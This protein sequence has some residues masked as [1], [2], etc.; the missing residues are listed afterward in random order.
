MSKEKKDDDEE[1]RKLWEQ[2]QDSSDALD[3]KRKQVIETIDRNTG[4]NDYPCKLSIMTALDELIGCFALGGQFKHY[5]RYGS[6]DLCEKQRKK[7]WFALKHGSLFDQKDKQVE[8]LSETELENQVQVQE[9]YKKRLL[10][11]KSNGSSEDVW[12]AREEAKSYPF[13]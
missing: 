9:F 5:Y 8:K 1:L 4:L 6:Y 12:D 7:F 10:Q 13:R 2:F 11:E 3:E